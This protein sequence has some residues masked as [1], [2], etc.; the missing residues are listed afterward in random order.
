MATYEHVKSGKIVERVRTVD[1]SREDT[2]LAA[3][4][5]DGKSGWRA[6]RPDDAKD[7]G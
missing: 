7:E 4:A 2:R 5:K 1:G 3:A 6:A